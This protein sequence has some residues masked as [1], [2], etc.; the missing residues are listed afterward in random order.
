[1]RN[2]YTAVVS[3]FLLLVVTGGN[4]ASAKTIHA[5]CRT[6]FAI[7]RALRG[8]V[9]GDIILVSGI[10]KD[11][12]NVGING[13]IIRGISGAAILAAVSDKP[14]ISISNKKDVLIKNLS[15]E[16]GPAGGIVITEGATATLEN[17]TVQKNGQ[18]GITVTEGARTTLKNVTV[19]ENAWDNIMV[20]WNS[21]AKLI[22]CAAT[23]G[24]HNGIEVKENSRLHLAGTTNASSNGHSGILMYASTL[25]TDSGILEANS[26]GQRGLL[27]E[28]NSTAL[29]SRTVIKTNYNR[30]WGI[31]IS[32]HST[33]RVTGGG[34][35]L[36]SSY[37][38]VQGDGVDG[39]GIFQ[40]GLL[41]LF[42][43]QTLLEENA[44]SGLNL[45]S[46]G[47]L[48]ILYPAFMIVRNNNGQWCGMNVGDGSSARMEEG[49][50]ASISILSENKGMFDLCVGHAS[51]VRTNGNTIYPN[52]IY[53]DRQ[54]GATIAGDRVCP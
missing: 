13:V 27:L 1:M 9:P 18:V 26:N 5:N 44:N 33:L 22:D 45:Y 6:R 32:D 10:C 38:G 41:E 48:E 34:S 52:R 4:Q 30:S 29:F 36:T 31:Q 35:S 53:C 28:L 3:V 46:G 21:T 12:V 14:I 23:E 49:K 15:L 47:M 11:N 25:T 20:R 54:L 37:N 43:G 7:S 40:Y 16:Y 8:A 51:R 39:I 19:R 42:D 17:V 24:G 50:D 2:I